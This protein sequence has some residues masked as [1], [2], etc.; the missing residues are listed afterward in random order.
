MIGK[1]SKI[2]LNRISAAFFVKKI[3]KFCFLGEKPRI[4]L[5]FGYGLRAII[6]TL[7]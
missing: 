7:E 3:K 6:A 1:Q 4:W 2:G 5:R